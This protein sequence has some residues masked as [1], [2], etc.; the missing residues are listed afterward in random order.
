MEVKNQLVIMRDKQTCVPNNDEIKTLLLAE[1]HDDVTARH[2]GVERTLQKLQ[3]KWSWKG[4]RDD[5]KMY[6][7]TCVKCQK[8]NKNNKRVAGPMHPIYAS[9]PGEIL[10]FD[11]VSGMAP[12]ERTGNTYCLII[13]DKFSR[14]VMCT[15]YAAT[16]NAEETARMFARRVVPIFGLPMKVIS[17]RGPQ[18]TAA[19]WK[20]FLRSMGC[21]RVLATSHHPQTDGLS[22]RNVQTF[23]HLLRAYAMEVKDQWENYL[24]HFEMAINS[25]VNNVTGKAPYQILFGR[26]PRLPIDVM[27]QEPL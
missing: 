16:V 8:N 4:M 19:L 27:I 11:F 21:D 9:C 25:A 23:I 14:F 1:A 15:A 7:G 5:V 10:T 26:M 2:F 13:C 6:V 12:A 18:F 22:E 24:P 17:D 20:T 3:T